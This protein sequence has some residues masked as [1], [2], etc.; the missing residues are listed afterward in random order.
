M[1]ESSPPPR[2][3][4][5]ADLV[6]TSLG[7]LFDEVRD[8]LIVWDAETG[9][10][11]L[12]NRAAETMFGHRPHEAIGQP[13]AA[14]VPLVGS[15][16]AGAPWPALEQHRPARAEPVE[17]RVLHRDGQE[18]DV[19]MT[20]SSLT[21]HGLAQRFVLVIVRDVTSR[22]RLEFRHRTAEQLA[23][24]GSWEWDVATGR[25]TWSDE[26]YRLLGREPGAEEPSA[27]AFLSHV[28]PGDRETLAGLL[29]RVRA[30]EGPLPTTRLR[31]RRADGACRWVLIRSE[32]IR[33]VDGRPA[34]LSGFVLDTTEVTEAQAALAESE[35]RYRLLAENAGDMIAVLAPDG[36]LRYVSPASRSMLGYDPTDLVGRPFTWHMHEG[37]VPRVE[38]ALAVRRAGRDWPRVTLRK[39]PRHGRW[40][41]VECLTRVVRD[42]QDLRE[43]HATCRDVTERYR[44]DAQLHQSEQLLAEAQALTHLG[45]WQLDLETQVATW[46]AELYRIFGETP[47]TFSPTFE[48][49]LDR[50][51]PADRDRV[52]QA[53][54]EAI[55][56]GA[57]L[58]VEHRVRRADGVYRVLLSL[59]QVRRGPDDRPG[60]FFGTV[61]DITERQAIESKLHHQ[62]HELELANAR[63]K[64]VD[65]AKD[66]FLS[67]V[68]HELRTPLTAITNAAAILRR[69]TAGPLT[70]AQSRFVTMIVEHTER[71]VRL[72]GD[73]LDLQKMEAEALELVT[74][75]G[76]LGSMLRATAAGFAHVFSE[77][78]VTFTLEVPDTPLEACFDADRLTQ[79][80]LNLLSN[81]AKFTPDGGHVR[82]AAA[83]EGGFV[84]IA[85]RDTGPGIAEP[86]L[87]RIFFKF[88]Q[89]ADPLTRGVGGTGLGLAISRRLVEAHGGRLEVTSRPG[90]GSTFTVVLKRLEG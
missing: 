64:E 50:V 88:V 49:Y 23:H 72:V 37:D 73:I 48:A 87:E 47:E 25:V 22:K 89:T 12:W 67:I 80:I 4:A 26:L 27:A 31:V 71:L 78:G 1:S 17:A 54:L 59:G 76:D 5:D 53:K 84:R 6:S 46:S 3:S 33:R 57:P 29:E 58:A 16:P 8:A 43:V 70:E 74:R 82:L 66:E 39:R 55:R 52:R 14:L 38:S 65:R 19:E 83:L 62:K 32:V 41:W 9:R 11:V 24:L 36:T 90:E 10:I 79:V 85:V 28:L 7:L 18:L 45:S 81:A 60:T 15:A 63:L 75:P 40:V 20:L 42:G 30:G 86:D 35:R 21:P 68:S 56:A 69:Q 77:R 34:V 13:I 61:Q 2:P 51:H 44:A